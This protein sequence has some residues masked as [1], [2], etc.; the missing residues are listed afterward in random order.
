MDEGEFDVEEDIAKGPKVVHHIPPTP[1]QV[2]ASPQ[3]P[4]TIAI[5]LPEPT[6]LHITHT[7]QPAGYYRALNEGQHASSATTATPDDVE[8]SSI[9]WALAAV[10]VEPTLHEAL[11][12][13]DG[14]EWQAAVDYEINQLEKLKAWKIITPPHYA[15]IIPCHFVLATKRG[16][17]GKK[18]KLRAQLVTNGQHQKHG[19]DYVETFAPMTNMTTIC[20]VMSIATHCDWE[21][22]QIDVKSAY[23]NA[24]LHDDIY[25]CTPPGYGL[26]RKNGE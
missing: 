18:L 26:M 25:M 3:T 21:I 9:H 5:P 14:P 1:A 7:R 11:S 6:A 24:Q 12:G 13:P 15:N 4:P 2:P 20:A 16:P 23:L 10:E 19:I 8:H 22:H 17:D